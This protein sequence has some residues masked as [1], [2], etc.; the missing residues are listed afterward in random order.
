MDK[1]TL[2]LVR[3]ALVPPAFVGLCL[4]IVLVTFPLVYA[5]GDGDTTGGGGAD[6]TSWLDDVKADYGFD[7]DT[8]RGYSE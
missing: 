5:F 2:N 1:L 4:C 3:F 7:R 6:T 8:S